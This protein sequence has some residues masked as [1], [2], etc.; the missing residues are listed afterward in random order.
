MQGVLPI[1]P[2]GVPAF[3]TLS[4]FPTS[5]GPPGLLPYNYTLNL[6]GLANE[7]HCNYTSQSPIVFTAV[8][9]GLLQYNGTCPAGMDVLTGALFV[10][11]SG[12]NTLGFWACQG[13]SSG[14]L[15]S[16]ILY[17]SGQGFYADAIG[18]IECT[19]SGVQPATF[20]LMYSSSS[21]LFTTQPAIPSTANSST[22][23]IV[24]SVK[25]LGDI[26]YESQGWQS[27]LVAE[28]IITFGVKSFGLAPYTPTPAYLR[29]Y[30]SM[31][32]G[33]LEY[34]VCPD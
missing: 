14:G 17:L 8:S 1:G 21:G 5:N 3:N 23:L 7:I 15:E 31:L 10:V 22:D 27:N 18:N 33:I 24:R 20:P 28:S 32:E 12:N 30:E 19:I 6:Q 4:S 26:V 2:N 29:L 11:P 25:A 13:P 9:P 16:F 34:Q